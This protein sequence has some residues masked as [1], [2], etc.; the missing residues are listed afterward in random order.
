MPTASRVLSV[1]VPDDKDGE[2]LDRFLAASID[3]LSRT[4]L[5]GLIEG[6]EVTGPAG[7]VTG[8]RHKVAAGETYRVSV[9]GERTGVPE[10]QAMALD[11]LYEDNDII[12]IDKPSG[13]V[14]HPAAGHPD[15]TLVN[16]LLAH[17]GPGFSAVGGAARPGIVHRLDIGTSGVMIAAKSEVAYLALT[18][19]FAAHDIERSY[20]AVV[21]GVPSPPRGTIDA[22][23][24]RSPRN[25]KKMAV[26]SRGGKP[27]I[28]HYETLRPG[29]GQLA[30]VRCTLETG[31]THQ[32]RVHLS[33]IGHPIVGDPAYGRGRTKTRLEKMI[34][35]M[36]EQVDRPLLHA[37]TLGVNHPR[38]GEKLS[39]SSPKPIIFKGIFENF[40]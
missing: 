28:T 4:R 25:R 31:R 19:D 7:T 15:G 38:T 1:R 34:G 14:V 9:P 32:I 33:H 3:D 27:A 17:C 29:G 24:G 40:E 8:P 37:V 11:I 30:L 23:I 10:P 16:A 6:G 12:V 36:A 20:E 21:W 18:R 13:L 35:D 2:R 5:Q 39:F 22:N 26:L